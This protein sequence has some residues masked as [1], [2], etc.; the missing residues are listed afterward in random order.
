[1][2]NHACHVVVPHIRGYVAAGHRPA[3]RGAVASGGVVFAYVDDWAL[4]AS[5]GGAAVLILE[6]R[7]PDGALATAW[8]AVAELNALRL[9]T[10]AGRFYISGPLLESDEAHGDAEAP[11]EASVPVVS[12]QL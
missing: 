10:F 9:L 11:E 1:M 7:P 5:V 2:T 8:D 3:P 12:L 4:G 6:Q